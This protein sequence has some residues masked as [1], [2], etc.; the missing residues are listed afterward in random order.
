MKLTAQIKLNPTTEQHK[1][2][3]ETL[4]EFNIA[5]QRISDIAWDKKIFGQYK[6]HHLVYKT[7]RESTKLSAQ[8]VIRSTGKVAD[9][10]KLDKKRKRK[11]RKQGSA[12]YDS[13]ILSYNFENHIA[14][15]WTITGREKVP[16]IISEHHKNLLRFQQGESDL[17]F[18]RGKWYLLAAC[19]VP[20]D[21]EKHFE[22]ILGVDLGIVDIA[23]DSTGHHYSGD[24]VKQYRDKRHKV[25]KSL[26]SKA[27]RSASRSTIKNTRRT[28]KRLSGKES[29]A[30]RLINHTIA[31]QIVEK[32]VANNMA[33]ALEDLKGILKSS[34]VR[35]KQRRTHHSWSFYQLRQ[36][37]Q[38][39]A[40]RVGIPV[41]LIP[42]AYTSKTC[43]I[44]YHIGVRNGK[45]FK[46]N[47]CGN[48]MDADHNAAMNIATWGRIVN[49]PEDSTFACSL[50][51][52]RV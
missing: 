12:T 17:C 32:A 7:I 48:V 31:K 46:C 20:N 3:L 28:L 33:I 11:F 9:A 19:D 43:S 40:E 35:K 29:R 42:P 36:F 21:E 41:F 38:Y 16:M 4:E 45:Y 52:H 37:I 8:A 14:S 24:Q 15:I 6:L 5:C 10:Y 13:R 25:R 1:T 34:K 27:R 44:C 22:H 30:I 23:S 26:Q 39:K 47:N 51:L 49:R 2:L 18:I 50:A